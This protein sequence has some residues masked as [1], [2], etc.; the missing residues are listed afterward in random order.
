[1]NKK[2]NVY[3]WVVTVA[4]GLTMAAIVDTYSGVIGVFLTPIAKS[5]HEP[6]SVISVFYTILVVVMAVVIPFVGKIIQKVKLSW[7]LLITVIITALSAF[8]IANT[9]NL[10]VFYLLAGILGICMAFGGLVVQGMVINNW[11]EKRRNF[12]FSLSSVIEAIFIAIMTPITSILIQNLGWKHAFLFLAILTLILG[13]PSALIVK[14]K[15]QEVGLLPYGA[16]EKEI[17]YEKNNGNINNN[18]QLSTKKLIVSGAFLITVLFTILVQFSGNITQ[19]FPTYGVV[20]GIGATNGAL[21]T[22]IVSIVGIVVIPLIG[23]SC[24]K[25]GPN[26]ALPFWLILGI[27]SYIIL[28]IATQMKSI[29]LSLLGS[30]LVCSA[31]GL[32][33]SGQE[34]FAKYMFGKEFEKGFSLV[35]SISYFVGSFI[36]PILSGIYELSGSFLAVFLFCILAAFLM[37]LLVI[38][39]KKKRIK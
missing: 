34:I 18:A 27:I 6:I 17:V 12:A 4:M 8:M 23:L 9:K 22:S 10:I 30:V 29:T 25:F 32:F 5:M 20:T 7:E 16:L 2:Q 28:C 15:P 39:G 33:G 21:M 13:I 14:L 35:T 37:I 3:P 36:M 11:F 19:L 31:S 38:I 26:K 24:D 1:M